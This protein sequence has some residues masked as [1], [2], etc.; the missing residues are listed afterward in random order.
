MPICS[1][2]HACFPSTP[3]RHRATRN[4]TLATEEPYPPNVGGYSHWIVDI[5]PRK[6]TANV[7][8]VV[9]LILIVIFAANLWCR[10]RV[11]GS[12]LP[13]VLSVMGVVAIGLG[14]WMG[15]EMVYVKGMAV[16]AVEEIEKKADRPRLRRAS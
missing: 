15:G 8:L 16:E 12:N 4:P 5:C 1:G 13:L 2:K 3:G 14:G 6:R 10:F 11:L 7:H 9:N